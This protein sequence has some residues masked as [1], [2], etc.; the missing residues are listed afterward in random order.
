MNDYKVKLE[1]FEGP[2]DLLLHLIKVHEMEIADI[3]ISV[4]TEQ[5]LA[6]LRLMEG[7]D[8]EVAGDF[9]V[10]ASTLLNIKLRSL[11][12]ADSD[13]GEEEEEVS[14][15]MTAQALMEKLVEYR[16]FKEASTN[17]RA[18]ASDQADVFFREVA[19]PKL[20]ESDSQNGLSLELDRLLGAFQRVLPF[21]EVDRWRFVSEEEYTVEEKMDWL[22]RQL[23]LEGQIDIESMFK[24]CSSKIEMIVFLLAMLELCQFGTASIGQSAAYEPIYLRRRVRKDSLTEGEGE[25]TPALVD[26]PAV[27]DSP[28]PDSSSARPPAPVDTTLVQQPEIPTDH[29]IAPASAPEPP[30]N[31]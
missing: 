20:V 17:L 31:D 18:Q 19:L 14:D 22:E 9:L 25:A 3:K 23:E 26:V 30:S 27:A 13:E 15:L 8:L 21:I 28:V 24:A 16:K 4:I 2:L 6:Y 5:Y 10:M 11:L 7:L 1:I 29:A 12:P